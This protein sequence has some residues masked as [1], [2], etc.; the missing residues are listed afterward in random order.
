MIEALPLPATVNGLALHPLVVHVV[1]VLV[2]LAVVGAIG[3]CV[4]PA[5]RRHLGLLVLGGAFVALVFVPIA[6][7]SGQQFRN[8]LG[9]QQLVRQHQ[10]YAR[11]ML[12]W[13]ATLFVLIALV[14]AIDLARRLGPVTPAVLAGTPSTATPPEEPSPRASSGGVALA[15]RAPASA[16]TATTTRLDR[17]VGGLLPARLREASWLARV[18]PVLAV[19][20]IAVAI[21]LA[22]YCFKTGES[23][24]KAV[25]QGR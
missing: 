14:M 23:G 7:S 20:T 21:V 2:P 4:W 8:H 15:T 22:W 10:H 9:A 16:A 17:T 11:N 13:T 1:V 5:M 24:A 25:W 6:T 12:P 18:Q 3:I 19:L